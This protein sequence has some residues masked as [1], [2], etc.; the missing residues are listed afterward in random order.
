MYSALVVTVS[1]KGFAGSR[2]DTA[3]PAAGALLESAGFK[4]SKTIIVPDEGPQIREALIQGADQDGVN[5]ILTV[6]GT[7]LSPRDISP[8]ATMAVCERMVPGIAEAMRRESAAIT[9]R[10]MLSRGV[11]GIRGRTLIVNLPG[12]EKGAV[13]N[14]RAVL[15][16]LGHGLDML[17]G[18]RG[19]CAGQPDI[20]A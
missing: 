15:D 6:G 3:G 14:L 8:E 10:A 19:E 12:S 1:D 7:G 11:A 2:A 20:P 18:T 17:L 5:L 9:R 16:T 13:E 4:V